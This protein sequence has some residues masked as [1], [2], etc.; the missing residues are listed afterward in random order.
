MG[1]QMA[2]IIGLGCWGG[3]ALD[4]Y[5]QTKFP[6][7]TIVLSLSSVIVAIYWVVKDLLKKK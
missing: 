1:F 2:A 3:I 4:S 7:F 5:F 6:G